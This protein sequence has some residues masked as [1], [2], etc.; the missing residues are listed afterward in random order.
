MKNLIILTM[1]LL[2][3]ACKE[4]TAL[5]TID[6]PTPT[7]QITEPSWA[8]LVHLEDLIPGSYFSNDRMSVIKIANDKKTIRHITF[9]KKADEG[10]H[11]LNA[12]TV[13][14]TDGTY[15]LKVVE[16][17][18]AILS[19]SLGAEPIDSDECR[20][21]IQSAYNEY[22]EK[23]DG[24]QFVFQNNGTFIRSNTLPFTLTENQLKQ[25][26]IWSIFGNTHEAQVF[27]KSDKD[28]NFDE[29][30]AFYQSSEKPHICSRFD[31]EVDLDKD[32]FKGSSDKCPN[33]K[34]SSPEGCPFKLDG[35]TNN[36]DGQAELASQTVK[37]FKNKVAEVCDT[38]ENVRQAEFICHKDLENNT[39]EWTHQSTDGVD[40]SEFAHTKC[41]HLDSI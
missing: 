11:S 28:I 7:T 22:I 35:F 15:E 27:Q 26:T 3:V 38:E 29:V 6:T 40:L 17:G 39:L 14:H 18:K 5:K 13:Q 33:E 16:P 24:S 37:R 31:P 36:C 19:P 23:F 30:I 21:L 25:G 2:S 32:G 12:M 8:K 34:G 4:S 1:V 9:S 41:I 20:E 10:S